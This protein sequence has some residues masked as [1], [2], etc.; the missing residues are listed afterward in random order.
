MIIID[1]YILRSSFC[2]S[3]YEHGG[4]ALYKK[5]NLNI[6]VIDLSSFCIPYKF[7]CR[8]IDIL[9]SNIIVITV[10]HPSSKNLSENSINLSKL[11][12]LISSLNI[13]TQT[14]NISAIL[15]WIF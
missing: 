4:V 13:T 9:D 2:R 12:Q 3:E 15:I 11:N 14:I 7:E 8:A 10:Y 6:K 5:S 1:N